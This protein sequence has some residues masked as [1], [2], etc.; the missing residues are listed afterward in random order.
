MDNHTPSAKDIIGSSP[1]I[2]IENEPLAKLIVDPPLS[3]SLAQG[4]VF[5]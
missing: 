2:A 5:I 1:L 4:R 3:E